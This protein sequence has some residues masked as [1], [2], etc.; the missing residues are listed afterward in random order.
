MPTM[1]N[2]VIRRGM[3]RARGPA[4]A[5]VRPALATPLTI[6]GVGM[7]ALGGLAWPAWGTAGE[8]LG[9]LGGASVTPAQEMRQGT[10]QFQQG[11]FAQ[12]AAHWMNAARGYEESGQV[13]EQCQALIN[14][15]YALQQEGQ[16][17]RAQGSL[18]AALKLS[19]QMGDRG[20]TATIF[21]QLGNTF[22]VLG[23]DEPAAEHLT[24]ALTLAREE[25][26]PALVAGVLNDLGNA[27]TARQQFAE[28]IDV[29]AESRSLAIETKQSALA[30]TAQ[31]NGAMALFQ[32]QQ[33]GDAHRHLD[34]AWSDV[35]LLGDSQAKTAA[36][37]N[38]GLG[39]QDLFVA[40]T[41]K[42][43]PAK[44]LDGGKGRATETAVSGG[45]GAGL[46]RQ[47]SEAFT[48]AGDVAER[49][50]D[51]RGQSYA[52][53]YLGGLLEQ[54]HRNTEALEYSRKATFAA[55]K[56]N[57]PESLYRWQWQ[58]ARL[59][60]ADGKEE[61]ALAA[62][63]RAVTLLKPIRYE[64]SVGYQGRHHSY[65]DSVAPL[66]VEYED[67]LLRR[68]AVAKTPD[69]SE[70]LLVQVKD[71]IEV[72]HAAQLQDY[73][74]DDCVA[75]VASQ[76]KTGT[77]APGTAVVYPISFPDRLE[78]LMETAHGLKQVSVPVSGEK[79]TKEI[80]TFRRLI[81]DSRSQ[82][83]LASAQTLHGWLIAPLQQDL[84][85]AGINTLVMVAD[86]SLRTIP[87][88][89]LHD[90]RHFLVDS[91]AVA[92]TP[93]LELTDLDASQRRKGSLLSVGLTESV[94]GLSA[95]RYAETEVQAIRTLYGGKLL[96]NK[97]FSS[98]SLEEEIKDQGVGIVHVASQTVI[99]G[100]AR[101]SYVLAHDGKITLDRLSQLVG[102]QQYRQQPLDLL[103]LSSC[104]IPAE[105]DRAALGLTGV[106]V[107]TG[108]RTVLATLWTTE[109]ETT[110][111]LVSEFYRQ[112]QDPALS[113]AVAL[114]RA[115]QKILAQR[116]HTHPS[117]WAAFLLINNW[118]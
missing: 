111:E 116:G 108:A 1:R 61:E 21:G 93:S 114:Q 80:R 78:L 26:K 105:D 107:K 4:A 24:K 84:Q 38:I 43:G 16:I 20:L 60:R 12:A 25:N 19:E 97:Q 45:S 36:L 106:A 115:Q 94:D 37:L 35:Q 87:M 54:E 5:S 62:Y 85:G 29:Y 72:S 101:D 59:L 47:S 52:W 81:Q 18:Q 73:Y 109:D 113:K 100:E 40:T 27:L 96:M 55:Q 56:V 49:T 15:A 50:G 42:P 6:L 48:A 58:T 83:Y 23:K 9:G 63:R 112:L 117:F 2:M 95:P 88:G 10:T 17:R 77:L 86:G 46:L 69:Q 41:A 14:L 110:S 8:L 32:N 51:A 53:G 91:L 39:Y 89:A 90:G 68:A 3:K 66:F 65:Y 104:E 57:A 33:L 31:I 79:L 76:R 98:P 92:V 64:Y 30:A 71:T 99:G 102:L 74:Q 75:T 28:A 7:L 70:Q 118:M 11:A 13:K 34:Q 103:T 82:N 44:K 67:V 22:H